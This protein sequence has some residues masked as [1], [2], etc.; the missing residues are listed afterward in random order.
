MQGGRIWILRLDHSTVR[1][2]REKTI[3]E[4]FDADQARRPAGWLRTTMLTRP[5]SLIALKKVPPDHRPKMTD[6]DGQRMGCIAP[7]AW[8]TA[9]ASFGDQTAPARAVRADQ[10]SQ[11]IHGVSSTQPRRTRHHRTI[12]SEPYGLFRDGSSVVLQLRRPSRKRSTVF[13]CAAMPWV[14]STDSSSARPSESACWNSSQPVAIRILSEDTPVIGMDPHQ[15]TGIDWLQPVTGGPGRNESTPTF[16]SDAA[17]A[18][19]SI[20]EP[21]VQHQHHAAMGIADLLKAS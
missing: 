8:A 15:C 16:P 9:L 10:S 2:N 21:A 7:V 17:D 4:R 12:G 18:D 5:S 11:S 20:L 1:K 14:P 3:G 6:I 13:N 19:G